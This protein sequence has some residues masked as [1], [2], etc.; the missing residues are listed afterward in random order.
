[1]VPLEKIPKPPQA[2]NDTTLQVIEDL[3]RRIDALQHTTPTSLSGFAGSSAAPPSSGMNDLWIFDSECSFHV[4][5][6]ASLLPSVDT[7]ASLPTI[8]TTDG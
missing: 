7:S 8:H 1:M 5:R 4:T 2:L 3:R 6:N